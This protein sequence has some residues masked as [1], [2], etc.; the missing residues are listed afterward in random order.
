MKRLF[1]LALFGVAT[2]VLGG[3]PV[4]SG[5]Q[6]NSYEVCNQSG[7]YWCPE[8]SM[9]SACLPS[10]QCDGYGNCSTD[11][12]APSDDTGTG[13]ITCS[14]PGACPEGYT[15]AASGTCQLGDCSITAC[16]AG[17]SCE[18]EN[19]T[20]TCV[21]SGP[22]N[23]DSGVPEEASASDSSSDD[24]GIACQSNADCPSTY[25]C[26]DG[27]CVPPSEQCFDGTQCVVGGD[28]CVQ[29]ACSPTCTVSED[30]GGSSCPA[31]YSCT[32]IEDASTS[33]VCSGNPTPC[34]SNPSV[35]AT[36]TVCAQNHCVTPCGTGGACAQGEECIQ[37]GCVP[38]QNAKF[39][40][41]TDGVQDACE[42]GSICID[43]NCYIACNPD[44][45]ATACQTA[46][47]FNECKPVTASGTTY[48]VC[49][50]STDLG[51]ECNPT[52]GQL[53]P[54]TGAICVD[55]YCY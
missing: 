29:G 19:G 52:L 16:V 27:A 41:T 45:G 17:Y 39:I 20:L 46:D 38:N 30:G 2:A 48:Y 28:K 34:E 15:C 25:L 9:S 10:G 44:A 43:R 21:L 18:L 31:G 13:T 36:G 23:V 33:G 14:Q 53:C 22:N 24:A 6:N 1:G 26:L 7:C 8:N 32:T 51:T 4:Y 47:Q 3:C 35:C 49:G 50:S 42:S 54:N 12:G 5:N 55:G 40:C 11:A 37:G